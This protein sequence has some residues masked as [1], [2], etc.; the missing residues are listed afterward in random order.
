[1]I[2]VTGILIYLLIYHTNQLFMWGNM[3][4]S[5]NSG[6]PKSSNLI[7]FSI[8]NHPFWGT[9]IFGNTHI[10]WPME[11]HHGKRLVS[12]R[13]PVLL[14][15]NFV[16]CYRPNQRYS[17]VEWSAFFWRRRHG[18]SN[19][20]WT[21][22]DDRWWMMIDAWNPKQPFI[23]G[24]FNWMIPNLYIENG[25]LGFQVMDDGWWMMNDE[26]WMMANG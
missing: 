25:C 1:M 10:P 22:M 16:Q 5:K 11:I 19:R 18:D 13:E 17:L 21:M 14:R 3:D 20:W 15:R 8:I 12:N 6:T 4:V 9:P 24:C 7:G 23:N 2:H 26:I